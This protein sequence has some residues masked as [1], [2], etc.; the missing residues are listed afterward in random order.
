MPEEIA[1][2][3]TDAGVDQDQFET[4][5]RQFLPFLATGEPL[6]DD[7]ALRDLGLDSMGTVELLAALESTFDV[8]FRDD[9]LS[10]EK[11]ANPGVLR[12][13]LVQMREI[14]A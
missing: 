9:A 3:T 14:S 8:R 6:A 10:M 12:Q 1:S 7:A 2:E 13:T 4:V 11:F 5:L